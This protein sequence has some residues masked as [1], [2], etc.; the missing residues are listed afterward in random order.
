[1]YHIKIGLF[2]EL[3]YFI[4]LEIRRSGGKLG[5]EDKEETWLP[6]KSALFFFY[7]HLGHISEEEMHTKS[8]MMII[9]SLQ[10]LTL[11]SRDFFPFVFY[12]Y[13]ITKCSW[14]SE[15]RVGR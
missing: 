6:H 10:Q 13:Q 5:E 11:F 4:Y 9:I 15:A 12:V 8:A 1:M 14:S 7:S 3:S 2:G